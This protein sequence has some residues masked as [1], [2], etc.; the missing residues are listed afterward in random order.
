MQQAICNDV[1]DARKTISPGVSHD[2]AAEA[3]ISLVDDLVT[4]VT[5]E[6]AASANEYSNSP[7]EFDCSYPARSVLLKSEIRSGSSS[8][9]CDAETHVG[10]ESAHQ[11]PKLHAAMHRTERFLMGRKR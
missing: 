11:F 5:K 1:G 3:E 7:S 4:G 9:S 2:E 6:A 10:V 8:A